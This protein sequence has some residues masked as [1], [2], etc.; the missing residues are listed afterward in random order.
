VPVEIVESLAQDSAV[1]ES[2]WPIAY[3]RRQKRDEMRGVVP[4]DGGYARPVPEPGS[5]LDAE[6]APAPF[7]IAEIEFEYPVLRE[8]KLELESGDDLEIFAQVT[9]DRHE[10]E[11]AR[12]LH[13]EGA[14]SVK[15]PADPRVDLLCPFEG[16][17]ADGAVTVKIVVLDGYEHRSHIERHPAQREGSRSLHLPFIAPGAVRHE[18]GGR[19]IDIAVR[20]DEQAGRRHVAELQSQ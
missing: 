9:L 14:A 10:E 20:C 17:D 5:R 1:L 19:G 6:N 7:R 8:K 4:R 3:R 18:H 2:G 11:R 15:R 12:D 13:R 16:R